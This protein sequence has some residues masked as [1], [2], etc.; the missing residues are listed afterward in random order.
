MVAQR[1]V[2]EVGDTQQLWHEGEVGG[3]WLLGCDR[4]IEY[5]NADR[6]EDRMALDVILCVVTPE[7]I[8]TLAVKKTAKE[9]W[10]AIKSIRVGSECAH[11]STLQRL[12][13]D[14]E[15]L[16]FH[17]GKRADDFVL[18]LT[19]MM[20]S[21]NLY[22]EDITEQ[23]AFE[24]LLCII[25]KQYKQVVIAIDTLLDTADLSIEEVTDRLKAVNDDD[26]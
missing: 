4:P 11:K 24:K 18:R 23:R 2:K 15:L 14:W 10:E 16:S 12:Q 20:S 7:L 25:P 26:G 3:L 9:A 21:L 1:V 6:T 13:R 17:D 22:G 19:G 5:S 8:R